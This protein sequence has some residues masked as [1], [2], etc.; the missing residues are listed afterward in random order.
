MMPPQRKKVLIADDDR[1]LSHMLASRLRAMGWVVDVAMDAMQ[2]VM[3]TRQNDPDIIVLDIA[4]PG[5]TGKKA[6]AS[7]KASSKTRDIPVLVLSGSVEPADEAGILALGAAE[8][9]RKP[10]EAD[11]LDARLRALLGEATPGAEKS[12]S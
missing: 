5:G 10:I 11:A 3:F 2:A 7:L 12:S 6:L 1:I 9:V 4:M 8:F